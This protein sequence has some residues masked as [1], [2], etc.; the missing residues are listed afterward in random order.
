MMVLLESHPIAQT[1]HLPSPSL[2]VDGS[3]LPW[4]ALAVFLSVAVQLLLRYESTKW[5]LAISIQC[6]R[7]V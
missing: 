7:E 5:L 6:T 2:V 4:P 3:F 1:S